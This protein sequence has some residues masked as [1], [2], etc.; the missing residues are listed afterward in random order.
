MGLLGVLVADQGRIVSARALDILLLLN[1]AD[2]Y[3]LLNLTG[4]EGVSTF[5]GLAGL[6]GQTGLSLPALVDSAAGVDRRTRS[7]ARSPCSRADRCRGARCADEL[8][9]T[10]AVAV[11]A[12]CDDKPDADAPPPHPIALDAPG[13]FCGM[14]LGEHPGPKGQ[15]FVRDRDGS[16][17]VRHRSRN[18]CIHAVAGNAEGHRGNL[19]QRRGAIAEPGSA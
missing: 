11:L 8:F 12:G 18:D 16:V 9:L 13:Q 19:C 1:P 14:T 15:I 17:L 3:R 10:I 7:V 5:A 6:A 2:A 4:T